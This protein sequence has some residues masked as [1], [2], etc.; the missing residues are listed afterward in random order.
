M[1]ILDQRVEQHEKKA[2]HPSAGRA[3]MDW[4]TTAHGASLW[5]LHGGSLSLEGI[6]H[7]L[8][9]VSVSRFGL[10]ITKEGTI[11]W[12]CYSGQQYKRL[13]R[14]YEAAIE[15]GICF[16]IEENEVHQVSSV[17]F[18][19]LLQTLPAPSFTPRNSLPKTTPRRAIKT[20]MG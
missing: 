3:L 15:Q 10:L 14:R 20:Q 5:R 16:W 9:Q 4:A 1:Q 13:A 6:C 18:R 19:A 11:V 2:G 8:D 12:S 7:V 17:A